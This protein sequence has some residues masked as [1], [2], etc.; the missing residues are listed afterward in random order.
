M[1]IRYR[2][3]VLAVFAVVHLSLWPPPLHAQEPDSATV[4][5]AF[6]STVAANVYTATL[7]D[8]ESTGPGAD[9]LADRGRDG[10]HFLM[11]E[12]N[13]TAEIPKI[14]A[15]LYER[16]AKDGYAPVALEIGPFAAQA[17]NERKMG[18]RRWTSGGRGQSLGPSGTA[19]RV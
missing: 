2:L 11:R 3:S 1:S 4:R 15:S 5:A 13:G 8:G 16:L 19:R 12:R 14:A 17:T 10:D 6:D 7:R 18:P 9:C